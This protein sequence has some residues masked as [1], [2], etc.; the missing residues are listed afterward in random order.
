[1]CRSR[2][3]LF[4]VDRYIQISIFIPDLHFVFSKQKGTVKTASIDLDLDLDLKL[5]QINSLLVKNLKQVYWWYSL[6]GGLS[7]VSSE[8]KGLTSERIFT[9][10]LRFLPISSIIPVHTTNDRFQRPGC[11][12]LQTSR[13]LS[14]LKTLPKIH[15]SDSVIL[16][17]QLYRCVT[18]TS[19]SY[20][21]E[22]E[23]EL[24][25]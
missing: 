3:D 11:I 19:S 7:F 12:D 1:M 22:Q 9:C 2:S 24:V 21:P 8:A 10:T 23:T 25:H 4:L 14:G 18:P 5:Q 16:L 13:Y 15:T 20:Q 17:S 6:L